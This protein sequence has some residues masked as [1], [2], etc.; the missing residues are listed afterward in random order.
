MLSEQR[1]ATRDNIQRKQARTGDER[2][3][4]DDDGG[5]SDNSDDDDDDY[6]IIPK[7]CL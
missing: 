4:S 3:D 5:M 6:R 7:I 2:E 1:S